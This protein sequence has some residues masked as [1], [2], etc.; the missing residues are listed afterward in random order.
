MKYTRG[1]TLIELMIVVAIVGILAAIAIPAY[2]DYTVRAKIT[3]ALAFAAAAKTT[4]SEYYASEGKMPLD[5]TVSGLAVG[6]GTNVQ[7][8]NISAIAYARAASGAGATN[9][10]GRYTV[11][12][13]SIGSVGEAD[14]EFSGTGSANGV[15]W[16]CRRDKANLKDRQVPSGCRNPIN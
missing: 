9:N 3:E 2:S 6:S 8:N 11:T 10:V 15:K 5:A 4:I 16:V 7:T 13:K 12:L 14:I 1:F